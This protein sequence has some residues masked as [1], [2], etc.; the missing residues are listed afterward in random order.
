MPL[1]RSMRERGSC[2][3]SRTG[4]IFVRQH[5]FT[6]FLRPFAFSATGPLYLPGKFSGIAGQFREVDGDPAWQLVLL[7]AGNSPSTS[8]PF[9]ASGI[10]RYTA[11]AIRCFA[12]G[13]SEEVLDANVRR[14]FRRLTGSVKPDLMKSRSKKYHW[15]IFDL[16]ALICKPQNPLCEQCPLFD[17]CEWASRSKSVIKRKRREPG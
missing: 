12:Y 17:L 14:V 7:P 16:A 11:T 15:A 3:S 10:G 9:Q 5:T 1:S 4:T 2:L 6:R 8:P 13:T